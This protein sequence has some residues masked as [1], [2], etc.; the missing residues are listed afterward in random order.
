MTPDGKR[1]RLLCGKQGIPFYSHRDLNGM[2]PRNE[3]QKIPWSSIPADPARDC[4]KGIFE[5]MPVGSE[6]Q[7][8][9]YGKPTVKDIEKAAR[10]A[11]METLRQK[12]LK[13]ISAGVTTIDELQRWKL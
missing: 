13:D 1:G 6:L 10:K 5:V 4:R 9:L 8:I 3:W 7:E 11:G 12:C 2:F